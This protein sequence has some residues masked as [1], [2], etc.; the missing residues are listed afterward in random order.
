MLKGQ[1]LNILTDRRHSDTCSNRARHACNACKSALVFSPRVQERTH[2]ACKSARMQ[3]PFSIYSRPR[4]A[5][6]LNTQVHEPVHARTH[7]PSFNSNLNQNSILSRTAN[8]CMG[9]RM[10][11]A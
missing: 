8:E 1:R 5:H 7:E 10:R 4:R 9:P 6:E 11:H 2:A 3:E